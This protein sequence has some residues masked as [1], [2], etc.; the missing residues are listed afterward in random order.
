MCDRLKR[1]AAFFIDWN[2]ILLPLV[3]CSAILGTIIHMYQNFTVLLL[4]FCIAIIGAFIL[5][6]KRDSL[7]KGQSVGKHLFHLNIVDAETL[8]TV[9]G[10]R[11]TKRNLFLFLLPV[12]GLL[13]L[14][15]GR[16]IGDRYAGTIVL[17]Q[18][19]LNI[20]KEDLH[21]GKKPCVSQNFK[22]ANR[23]ALII[24]ACCILVFLGLIQFVLFLQTDSEEY[25]I[26]YHYLVNSN[27]FTE[28]NAKESH[29]RI[30]Q[31]A[32]TRTTEENGETTQTVTIGFW[33]Q[34]KSYKVIMHKVNDQW[35]V[36]QDC[37]PF[38]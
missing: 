3:L 7:G 31:Y 20:C 15:T 37:T 35:Q 5:I 34:F 4:L 2:L 32:S 21:T 22:K 17:S 6:V 36:C 10:K 8:N 12:E 24:A 27:T 33:V 16:T 9:T 14:T 18:E 29:I 30:H 23:K 28:A 25:R 38:H 26:A 13:L 1:I 19:T 11:L